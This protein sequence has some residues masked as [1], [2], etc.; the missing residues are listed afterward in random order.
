M[1]QPEDCLS[2]DQK[3]PL[4]QPKRYVMRKK[5]TIKTKNKNKNPSTIPPVLLR[6]TPYHNA[7]KKPNQTCS[8]QQKHA[9]STQQTRGIHHAVLFCLLCYTITSNFY[10]SDDMTELCA[11]A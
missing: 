1:K 9:R 11:Y 5:I 10:I 7:I 2:R 6:A 4:W 8:L 3:L